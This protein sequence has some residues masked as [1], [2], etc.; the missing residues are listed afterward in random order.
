M[1]SPNLMK[2]QR[3]KIKVFCN[4]TKKEKLMDKR[5]ADALVKMKRASYI[6]AA[7]LVYETKVIVPAFAPAVVIEPEVVEEKP[8]RKKKKKTDDQE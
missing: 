4:V 6:V 3:M 2:G 1:P 7:P 8:K 5:L